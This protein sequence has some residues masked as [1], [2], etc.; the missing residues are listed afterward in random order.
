MSRYNISHETII[1][2]PVTKVWKELIAID[3]WSWNRWT[4]L[5]SSTPPK[6]GIQGKL[7]ASYD[8]NDVWKEFDFTFGKVSESDYLLTWKG[9]VGLGGCL[10]SGYH[11]M[12]LE[13]VVGEEGVE[14]E[15]SNT[16]TRLIHREEFGGLLAKLGLGLP[17]K[18]LDRNYLLMNEALKECVEGKK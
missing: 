14:S 4:K 8:G 17:Y 10:F 13:E 7:L 16:T 3:D 6:E 11:T 5:K 12:R 2:A 15:T 9:S 18:T 1:N